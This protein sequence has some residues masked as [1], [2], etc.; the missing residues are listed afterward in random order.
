MTTTQTSLFID[1]AWLIEHGADPDCASL[2]KVTAEWLN[3]VTLSRAVLVRAA[4][5]KV[6]LTWFA[7]TILRGKQWT[8]YIAAKQ[9]ATEAY[10]A[11][12]VR[13]LELPMTDYSSALN[14]AWAAYNLAK[15]HALADALGLD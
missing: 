9:P 6:N 10:D 3:G 15:A 2:A 7:C 8:T 4:R 11:A 12:M 1:R 5:L 14:E 13:V